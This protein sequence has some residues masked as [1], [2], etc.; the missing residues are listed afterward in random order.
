MPQASTETLEA[1]TLV[2][3]LFDE[4]TTDEWSP[5]DCSDPV[6][7]E[8]AVDDYL[9]TLGEHASRDYKD[10]CEFAAVLYGEEYGEEYG[11]DD[12]DGLLSLVQ[13]R[14][15]DRY[16]PDDDIDD[17]PSCP[18]YSLAEMRESGRVVTL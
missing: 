12:L 18:I 2:I 1:R 9:D 11:E 3:D 4:L 13:G 7:L 16:V 10:A 8:F 17:R 5:G 15:H 14:M 6:D